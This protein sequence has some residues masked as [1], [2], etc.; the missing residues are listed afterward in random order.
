LNL[1]FNAKKLQ[2]SK[3]KFF[4]NIVQNDFRN[5]EVC[6]IAFL[7]NKFELKY[8]DEKYWDKLCS[9]NVFKEINYERNPLIN[10]KFEKN[11]FEEKQKLILDNIF[12]LKKIPFIF[13]D[14]LVEIKPKI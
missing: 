12:N 3:N 2:N 8:I 11:E 14:F 1:E 7:N 6:R 9:I 13:W 4:I 10:L 5:E